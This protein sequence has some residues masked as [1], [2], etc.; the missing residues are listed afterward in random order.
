AQVAQARDSLASTGSA[1]PRT[2][3]VAEGEK[4]R[5]QL[6]TGP[7][8]P[9]AF[10]AAAARAGSS[11]AALPPLGTQLAQL[12]LVGFPGTRPGPVSRGLVERGVGGLL[13][14]RRNVVSAGQV[15]ALVA[16]LKGRAR[17]P[18]EVAVDQEPGTRVARLAGIV[19]AAPSARELGRMPAER[20][21]RYGR[22]TGRDL[23][24][25]GITADLAPVLDVTGARWDGVIGDR[26]FGSDPATAGRA[27]VA[28]MRGLAAGG[29]APVGK[30]FPGHGATT[31]DSHHRLPVV[32]ASLARLHAHDLAPFRAAIRSGLDA[33]MVGHLV[34]RAVDPRTPATLSP[35]VVD[36]LLREQMGFGGLVVSD[37]L[38]MGAI[39]GTVSLP[40]AAER[41]VAAGVDQLVLSG[42]A[43]VPAVL[44]H[45]ERAVAAGRLAEARVRE[46]FL[47][48]QRFKRTGRWAG[49]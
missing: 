35:A 28:Y 30:H 9:S 25:L 11:C 16:D 12:L 42:H 32:A 3:R 6:S 33:I 36:G 37:A 39:A 10:S 20:V 18:L 23:A 19:R 40:V 43:A 41:A 27:A 24:A 4:G 13:L 31:V 21:E 46:A 22:A 29:V 44:G 26:S 17:I 7:S 34:V 48:V 1:G 14:F 2:G 15:R 5:F 49:C 45:L 8:A 47:R 38:E